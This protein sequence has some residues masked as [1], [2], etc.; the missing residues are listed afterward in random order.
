VTERGLHGWL[1]VLH[2]LAA[3]VWLGGAAALSA[4]AAWAV[5]RSDPG[6]VARFVTSLRAIGPV[7]FAP[8]PVILLGTGVWMVVQ[9]DDSSWSQGWILAGLGLFAAAFLVGAAYNSR[10]AIAAHRAAGRG[11]ATQAARQLRRWAWGAL[12]ICVL[13]AVATWDMVFKPGG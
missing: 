5:R 6:A 9:D 2:L 10:A 7:L 8:G 13:L 12:L 3:M 1:L 4:S 11:D